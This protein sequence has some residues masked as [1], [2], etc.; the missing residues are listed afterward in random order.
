MQWVMGVK[1][2]CSKMGMKL[3][4]NRMRVCES[5]CSKGLLRG[6][7]DDRESSPY[8]MAAGAFVG[9][10]EDRPMLRLVGMPQLLVDVAVATVLWV[11]GVDAAPR[12]FNFGSHERLVKNFALTVQVGPVLGGL[13]ARPPRAPVS[14]AWAYR[15]F[16]D[17]TLAAL[18]VVRHDRWL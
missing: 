15:D 12:V 10:T 17:D 5:V 6:T 4:Y 14:H 18:S 16:P 11:C 8:G 9:S 2:E 13:D 1:P 3:E 7:G